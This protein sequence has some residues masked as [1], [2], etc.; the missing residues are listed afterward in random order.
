MRYLFFMLFFMSGFAA[1][2][3]ADV[4]KLPYQGISLNANLVKSADSWPSG[5]VVVPTRAES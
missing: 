2:A 3:T 4:V 5:P 1:T